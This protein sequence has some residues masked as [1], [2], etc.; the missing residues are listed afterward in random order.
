MNRIALENLNPGSPES[1][2]QVEGA[3]DATIQGFATNISTNVGDTVDFK[4]A[5]DSTDYRIDIYRLGYYGGDG[6]RKVAS[7]E[8]TLDAPQI[9]PHPIVDAARGLIDAGNWAVSASWTIPEDLVSGVYVAKLVREDG[10]GGASHI[11]FIV[12]DDASTSDMVFQ[13]SDTTWQ[14]YNPWGGASL[15]GGET[16]LD[17]AD[18]I[19]YL[20]PNCGCGV[21]AIGRAYAVSYNRPIVTNTSVPIY[22]AGPHSFV[23]G[24][25]YSAIRWIEQNG[26][27][28][29]YISGIDTTRAGAELLDHKAFLSVGHDEYW[30]AEQRANVEAARDAGVNLAFLG[31]NDVFWK[32]RW[33]TSI[34]GSG[35]PYRTMVCYKES[36]A[37]AGIDPSDVATGTWRDPRFSDPGQEPENSLT[38]TAFTVN[39]FRF[40]TITIPYEFTQ[41]RFWRNTEVAETAPGETASLVSGILGIE[42]NSDLDNGYRPAGL[43]NL[44]LS[45]ISV[46][47]LLQD[48]GSTF[49][50]GEA[51]HSLT[52][53]RDQESGAL[54]FS[55][56]T[57]YW[58]WGLD[59]SHPYEE[60]PVDPSVKQAMVNLFADMGI[61]PTTLEASLALATGTTDF[62][63][64]TSS[65][66]APPGTGVYFEGQKVTVTGT[67][68]DLGGGRVAGVEVS[69]DNGL[70]W[71][72]AEGRETW[73]YTWTAPAAGA[74]TIRS[75]AA[76]DSLN[77]EAPA[78]GTTVSVTLPA[79][80]SF[81]TYAADPVV[82]W[83]MEINPIEVGVRFQATTNGTIDAIRFYKGA[84]NISAHSVRLWTADGT[85]LASA[86]STGE[87][88]SGWQTV[89]LASPIAIT[90]GTTYVA[91]YHTRSYYAVDASYFTTPRTSGFLTAPVN[92]GV[93]AYGDAG[94]FPAQSHNSSN[95]W[96]DVAFSAAPNQTPTAVA[97]AGFVTN[98]AWPLVIAF[99]ALLGNDT[100]PNGDALTITS[101]DGATNG[102]VTLDTVARTIRFAATSGYSGPAAF[103]YTVS[104]GRGGTAS[105]NV[106]VNVLPASAEGSLFTAADTPA[107]TGVVD[108]RAVELGV[109]FTSTA[110]GTITGLRFYKG[111]G[112]TGTHLGSLW[113]ASG[114]LLTS[115]TFTNET[116]SG[117]QTATFASAISI[118][119]GATYVASYHSNGVYAATPSFFAS[120][121]TRGTLTAPS[122]F[123]SGG[124]GVYAYGDASLF[125]SSSYN[126]TNYY[127]DVIF[128]PAPTNSAPVAANDSFSATIGKPLT[129]T[130]AQ[131]LANDTDPNADP[132]RITKVSNPINGKVSF[133]ATAGTVKFTPTAGY[134]GPA[135]FRYTITDGRGGTSSARVDLAVHPAAQSIF[136]SSAVP[137]ILT[138]SDNQPVELGLKFLADVAGQITGIKFYKSAANTGPHT[139]HL[140][141]STGALMATAAFTGETASGWQT[142]NLA[143]PVNIAAGTTY[144]ASYHTTNVYSVTGDFFNEDVVNGN[145]RALSSAASDGNGVFA[146]G[147]NG[148][149][150]NATYN[151]ANYYVDVVFRPQLAA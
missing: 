150:P 90:A 13:T 71:W 121:L 43:I 65:V 4:I 123:A 41:L 119:A 12:R 74:Y 55:A 9:Q 15:Y 21:S 126:S 37:H 62:V 2:W 98:P 127:V 93:Y 23:F 125:P 120:S 143:T 57:M 53:Y 44:S 122:S 107:M 116:S 31:G 81:W 38:G 59:S 94:S 36:W 113:T 6:A 54:V 60:V 108:G 101:V 151:N 5:T 22:A 148:T 40:D 47:T 137:T 30:S 112:E 86:A 48:W 66:L 63:A 39:A 35:T 17:P 117:W 114:S 83:E 124:N 11:P 77:L 52:M 75:R 149:F 115:V 50:P 110:V 3:G 19:G 100:D 7:I 141:S 132:L 138:A 128:K 70:S 104:D 46:D 72:K 140:W 146:Y 18:M 85:L 76:D 68:S 64:P 99:S 33:E 111:V 61:Q 91:S 56:G 51:T 58:T 131:L 109:K 135:S 16:P 79:T 25:E 49:G 69:F 139:G 89:T 133:N 28:V 78:T 144:V 142:A 145:L 1:E 97:D 80:N 84:A 82:E 92:A 106:A 88:L 87:T 73:S 42:W 147:A 32:V 20:P 103:S 14:A 27:D 26:Y 95:Y 102:T 24:A 134:T 96:V 129:L 45:T 10:S 130:V 34:D 118:T 67:A 8:K 105:A 29:S 136:S